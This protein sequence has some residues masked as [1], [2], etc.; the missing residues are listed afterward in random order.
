MTRGC[1]HALPLRSEGQNLV[2][3]SDARLVR[4]SPA[5]PL[6]MPEVQMTESA[7]LC[8]IQQEKM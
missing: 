4:G 5:I 6:R 8:F 7:G 1:Q 3:L 2:C